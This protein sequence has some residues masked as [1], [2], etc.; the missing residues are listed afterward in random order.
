MD[1]S[2]VQKQ[3]DLRGEIE[4]DIGDEA[5]VVPGDAVA[6]ESE[7]R[8]EGGEEVVVLDEDFGTVLVYS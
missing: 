6:V 4:V 2:E 8:A 7:H 3:K 5:A 1:A